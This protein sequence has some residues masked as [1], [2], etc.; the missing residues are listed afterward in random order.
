[1]AR[2]RASIRMRA[3]WLR[4]PFIKLARGK[5]PGILNEPPVLPHKAVYIGPGES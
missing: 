2:V 4:V 5:C 3:N 1:M